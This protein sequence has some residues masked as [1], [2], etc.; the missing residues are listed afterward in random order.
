M[1]AAGTGP[2]TT[3]RNTQWCGWPAGDRPSGR[4]RC[5]TDEGPTPGTQASSGGG[6]DYLSNE[7]MYR[8]NRLRLALGATDVAGGHLHI[9]ALN[10]PSDRTVVIDDAFTADRTATVDQ[11][12]ALVRAA[13]AAVDR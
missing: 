11:T 10:Y 5:F 8:S 12:V 2:W 13:G 1:I 9:S 3:Y 6:G 4:V 7:S